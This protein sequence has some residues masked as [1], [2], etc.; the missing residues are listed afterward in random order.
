MVPSLPLRE[1]SCTVLIKS[2]VL[3]HLSISASAFSL[4]FSLNYL[5]HSVGVFQA[6]N[7]ESYDIW[8]EET[9]W[10]LKAHQRAHSSLAT[11]LISISSGSISY[12]PSS[13]DSDSPHEKHLGSAQDSCFIF[14]NDD[15]G[16]TSRGVFSQQENPA[17]FVA[18]KD[19]SSENNTH[20]PAF[21]DCLSNPTK[22]QAYKKQYSSLL[23]ISDEQ[24][25]AI[26]DSWTMLLN[27]RIKDN[28]G[29]ISHGMTVLFELVSQEDGVVAV[30]EVVLFLVIL[31]IIFIEIFRLFYNMFFQVNP[32]ARRLFG[33]SGMKVQGQ[34][35]V[36]MLST[37]VRSLDNIQDLVPTFRSLGGRH[38]IYGI[39]ANDYQV[40]CDV[41]CDTMEEVIGKNNFPISTRDAW[42]RA[43]TGLSAI[44][45]D[46]ANKMV[47]D[48][49]VSEFL[50]K[51]KSKPWK[52]YVL[53]LHLS[54]L[55]F[56]K[57]PQTKPSKTFHL[58]WLK[59]LELI[60]D[61]R[62]DKPTDY[63]FSVNYRLSKIFFCSLAKNDLLD[64]MKELSWRT[65][66][67]E[68]VTSKTVVNETDSN[69]VTA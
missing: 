18:R 16:D 54:H 58:S 43:I 34:A 55:I 65:E 53:E 59:N 4:S 27:V 52:K 28:S 33:S 69:E 35:L 9:S 44:M 7:Q 17:R 49:V 30:S 57:P 24:K 32:T 15:Y 47:K 42:F 66:A 1:L 64:W 21:L 22:F 25:K 38:K 14:R 37:V 3:K 63:C 8:L 11:G 20:D 62:I 67:C 60:D 13:T 6:L 5:K 2:F 51:M 45:Q 31:A 40:F 10:R 56:Y 29:V 61:H 39:Q 19:V 41:F 48:P 12:N 23:A 50:V 46:A 68:K 36:R 26:K